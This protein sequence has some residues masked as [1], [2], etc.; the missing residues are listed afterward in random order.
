ML[1]E[2]LTILEHRSCATAGQWTKRR[3]T[4]CI[5]T[6]VV[7]SYTVR[8]IQRLCLSKSGPDS[9]T[10]LNHGQ[11]KTL[12]FVD[13]A[14]NDRRCRLQPVPER[15]L[16]ARRHLLWIHVPAVPVRDADAACRGLRPCRAHWQCL[17]HRHRPLAFQ[18]VCHRQRRVPEVTFASAPL[19]LTSLYHEP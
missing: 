17:H 15:L 19:L 11:C 1:D 7:T 8:R 5:H 16:A 14:C 12:R 3:A 2:L 18:R 9:P 13:A 6:S 4:C 10:S